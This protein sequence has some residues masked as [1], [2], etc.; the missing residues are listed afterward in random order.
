MEF[1]FWGNPLEAMLDRLPNAQ[2]VRQDNQ[3]A[4][5]KATVFGRGIKMW[6]LSQAEFV[7]VLGPPDFRQEMVKT[8]AKM[9]QVYGT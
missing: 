8:V 5:I 9:L 4:V 1:R 6:L 3:G 7:E 2:V